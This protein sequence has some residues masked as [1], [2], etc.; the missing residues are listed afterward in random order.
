MIELK[1]ERDGR[2]RYLGYCLS[3][4]DEAGIRR[5]GY[6]NPE[7]ELEH[8]R[9]VQEW[10]STNLT[11]QFLARNFVELLCPGGAYE[12]AYDERELA[13]ATRQLLELAPKLLQS[14]I[15]NPGTGSLEGPLTYN[16]G[17]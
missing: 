8:D 2:V 6:T 3:W 11:P 9:I 14:D 12:G 17:L 16:K 13:E 1:V 10:D 7:L 4:I 5:R 15:Y